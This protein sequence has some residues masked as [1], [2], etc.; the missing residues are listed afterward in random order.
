MYQDNIYAGLLHLHNVM[1]WIILMLLVLCLVQS[2][3]KQHGLA[4]TSLWLMIASHITLLI[5]IYQWL[6]GKLGLKL[7]ENGMA[8]VMS[9]GVSRFWAIEHA[10]A[11]ILAII[12]ITVARGAAKDHKFRTT[13]WLYLISL[14]V[15]LVSIPWPF[16]AEGLSRSWLPG[17]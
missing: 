13:T 12:L 6:Q 15:V 9:N 8:A 14:L 5:G 7:I 10:F 4:K 3:R 1:R 17:L 2:F 11:M 16:R